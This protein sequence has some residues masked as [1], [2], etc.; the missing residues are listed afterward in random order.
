[1]ATALMEL[2]VTSAAATCQE[3]S[4]DMVLASIT[5]YGQGQITDGRPLPV[6]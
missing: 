5:T 2:D 4:I 1:M 6:V 3:L